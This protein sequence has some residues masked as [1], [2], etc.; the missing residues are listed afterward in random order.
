MVHRVSTGVLECRA[1][2]RWLHVFGK[3]FAGQRLLMECDNSSAVQGIEAV[4]SDKEAMMI[5][6]TEIRRICLHH[7]IIMRTQHILGE[8][9]NRVADHLSHDRV[10]LAR[11][12]AIEEFGCPLDPTGPSRRC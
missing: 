10:P 5:E 4:Y 1:V 9:Y 12:T 2:L 11:S 7:N 8:L 3:R 6:I